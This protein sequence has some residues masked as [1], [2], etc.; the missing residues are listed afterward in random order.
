MKNPVVG[1]CGPPSSQQRGREWSRHA[2]SLITAACRCS[3]APHFAWGTSRHTAPPGSE[4]R[5]CVNLLISLYEMPRKSETSAPLGTG[6]KWQ[7]GQCWIL[8]G[9]PGRAFG[10]EEPHPSLPSLHGA[11]HTRGSHP[12]FRPAR[13]GPSHHS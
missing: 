8:S 11:T 6:G 3:G 10:Q 7:V 2:H 12:H 1:P 5:G 4:L 9:V 13:G